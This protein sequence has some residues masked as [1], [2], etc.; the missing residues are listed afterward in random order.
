MK[1]TK[2]ALLLLALLFWISACVP[3]PQPTPTAPAPA[4]TVPGVPPL[5]L[6]MLKNAGYSIILFD[7]V[8]QT[9][10]MTDGIYQSGSDPAQ[11][12][13]ISARMGDL[14]AFGDLNGDSVDDAVV[15]IN[16]N[17]GG[18]GVFTSVIAMINQNGVPVQPAPAPMEDLPLVNTLA[19]QDGEIFIDAVIHGINDPNCC[20]NQSI[21]KTYRL[22]SNG[23]VLMHHTTKLL[24]GSERIITI[25]SPAD[26]AEVTN[27]VTVTGSVSI[28]P[29][30]SNLVY[31]IYTGSGEFV[32]QSSLMVD[33]PDM[34]APGT[35]E[36]TFDLTMAGATGPIRVEF[37]DLSPADGSPLA[38]D[39]VMLILK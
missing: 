30:E 10:Q 15:I 3:L 12:D 32:N 37:W 23:L 21:T 8:P 25:Q 5:T 39:A 24:D 38:M 22:F 2:P 4:P 9:L 6:D 18:T 33:A 19:I 34:G 28:A 16:L 35:F 13:Y 1:L 17:F 11:P 31:R 36:L 26:G 29:F 14:A 27:P 20:P 7:D